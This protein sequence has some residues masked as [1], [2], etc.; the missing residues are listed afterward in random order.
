[1][2]ERKILAF[3]NRDAALHADMLAGLKRRTARILEASGE[4][5]LLFDPASGAHQ[6][7][8]ES[9]R[10][11]ERMLS[12][13][14]R[15]RLLALHQEYGLKR[16][17]E[18]YALPA[19]LSVR[20][21]AYFGAKPLPPSYPSPAEIR[22]LD[23]SWLPFLREHYNLI[24]DPGYLPGRIRAG[25]MA[26]AFVGG[27]PAGFAGV[28]EEGSV[29]MLEV[30]PPFRRRGIARMLETFLVNRLLREGWLPFAQID[31]GNGP[32]LSLHRRLG[33]TVSDGIVRWLM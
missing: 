31:P 3:L 15:A 9:E 28:H 21:A 20:H 10:A 26:G 17:R 29:G 7:S 11:A 24:P 30:L 32:S 5:V 6:L 12:A 33:F 4:G 25:A 18:Q 2:T 14:P 23:E 16:A 13:V 27:E 19:E 22:T 8:A 1:M